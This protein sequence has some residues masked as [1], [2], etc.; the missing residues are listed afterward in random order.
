MIV[1][2]IPPAVGRAVRTLTEPRGQTRVSRGAVTVMQKLKGCPRC[3]MADVTLD[4]D[5]YGRNKCCIQCGYLLS[6]TWLVAERRGEK[7]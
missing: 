4:R 2:E 1:I 5:D 6:S 7:D 3:K